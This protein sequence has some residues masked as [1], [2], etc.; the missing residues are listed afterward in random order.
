M[1]WRWVHRPGE[2]HEAGVD[3][4]DKVPE[5]SRESVIFASGTSVLSILFTC[6]FLFGGKEKKMAE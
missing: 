3:E 4:D 5:S 6:F 2:N 1:P